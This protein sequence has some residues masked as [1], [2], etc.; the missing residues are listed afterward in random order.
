MIYKNIFL[1]SFKRD[2]FC[3]NVSSNHKSTQLKWFLHFCLITFYLMGARVS[4]REVRIINLVKKSL[5]SSWPYW[6]LE[7]KK[8]WSFGEN[9]CQ[10]EPFFLCR[11]KSQPTFRII[12]QFKGLIKR[13]LGKIIKYGWLSLVTHRGYVPDKFMTRGYQINHF[14]PCYSYEF[15]LVICVFFSFYGP[16]IPKERV[17]RDDYLSNIECDRDRKTAIWKV[18][19]HSFKNNQRLHFYF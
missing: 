5:L 16:R 8:W 6:R 13:T 15:S 12:R 7:R 18:N 10:M 4:K 14:R 3:S 17:T 9:R 1:F 19:H 2:V 11:K